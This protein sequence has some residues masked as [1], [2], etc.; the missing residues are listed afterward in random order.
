[1]GVEEGQQKQKVENNAWLARMK[2]ALERGEDF[3][4]PPPWQQWAIGHR[5]SK[6]FPDR[7][8]SDGMY[9]YFPKTWTW[10]MPKSERIRQHIYQTGFKKGREEGIEIGL[11]EAR[12]HRNQE[13]ENNAWLAR[14][15]DAL[16]RGEDFNEPPPWERR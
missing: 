4:E 14:M 3:D 2:D 15:K 1:M 16:E 7:K 6:S 11:E 10:L 13:S 5:S 12:L 9:P 8:L